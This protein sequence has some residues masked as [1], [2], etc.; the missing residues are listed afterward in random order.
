MK[1]SC[2]KSDLV[3][4]INIARRFQI[5]GRSIARKSPRQIFSGLY[6]LAENDLLEIQ[7]AD[8]EIGAILHVKADIET[9]GDCV[10]SGRIFHEVIRMLPDDEVTV[11]NDSSTSTVII[12]SGKSNFSLPSVN[13]VAFPII[14]P[15]KDDMSFMVD[16]TV[17]KDL[18]YKTT[19]ACATNKKRPLFRGALLEVEGDKVR[20]VATNSHRLAF[21]EGRIEDDVSELFRYVIPKRILEEIEYI[22]SSYALEKVQVAWAP[23][24]LSFC[25]DKIYVQ[26][27]LIEGK[28]PEYRRV[29][30]A[31][32][33]RQVTLSTAAFLSAVSRVGLIAR[34]LEYNEIYLRFHN[35]AVYIS[36]NK[37]EAGKAE[38]TMPAVIYGEDI[39]IAFCHSYLI[40]VLKII[41]SDTF[42][43]EMNGSSEVTIIREPD[44]KNFFYVVMPVRM[45]HD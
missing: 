23:S 20:M 24:K 4:A 19:F 16:S 31:E 36:S 33:S 13:G 3:Y 32:F 9:S 22:L 39:E 18:I 25:V 27:R 30:P 12:S 8:Y 7:V 11:Q 17:L 15:I 34:T 44:N 1:F 5:A 37:T 35:N 14:Y 6:L 21:N 38:E 42:I 45:N 29:I 43:L 2:V 26:T 41:N 40:D 10:I 28:F